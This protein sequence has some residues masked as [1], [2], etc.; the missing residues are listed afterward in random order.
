M[1]KPF[2]I[3]PTS[4]GYTRY[5]PPISRPTPNKPPVYQQ[6]EARKLPL[7]RTGQGDFTRDMTPGKRVTTG[8]FWTLIVVGCGA[9]GATILAWQL[10]R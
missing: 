10:M 8:E 2:G 5:S 6:I 4:Y 3:V 1:C 9:I 7:V